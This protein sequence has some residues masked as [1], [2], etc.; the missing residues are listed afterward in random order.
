MELMPRMTRYVV[1]LV[2]FV[3]CN[4]QEERHEDG[5]IRGSVAKCGGIL[6]YFMAR[7]REREKEN[8]TNLSINRGLTLSVHV[9]PLRQGCVAHGC[10]TISHCSPDSPSA[11]VQRY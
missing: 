11:H 8:K 7:V 1:G 3:S 9:P 2:A 10:S 6:N 5:G 4:D